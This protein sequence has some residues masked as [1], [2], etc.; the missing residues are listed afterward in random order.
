MTKLIKTNLLISIIVTIISFAYA[1]PN[2]WNMENNLYL[3]SRG[4]N[5]GLDLRGGSH[6]LLKVDI[7]KYIEDQLE[8]LSDNLRKHFREKKMGYKS[9]KVD[10]NS[11]VVTL[12]NPEDAKPAIKIASSVDSSLV[13]E[14]LNDTI[15]A[16]Y[17]E[18]R[19]AT[20]RENVIDQSI[21]IVRMRVDSAG[22]KEPV[23]QKQGDEYIILQVPGEGN[24]EHLKKL[25]G[26]TA[27]LTLH[28]IE[29]GVRGSQNSESIISQDEYGNNIYLQKKPIITG[30]M[31]INAAATFDETS[32]PAINFS[33]NTIGAKLFGEATKNNKGKR[34]AIVLDNKILSSPRVSEPILRGEGV[35]KGSF[36]ISSAEDLAL[37]LRAGAL[38]AP[39]EVIEE[40]VIGASL[41]S[42]SIESGKKAGMIGLAGVMVFMVLSYGIL[43]I[44]A[45]IALSF[46]LLYIIAILS[47]IQA[48]LTLPGIAGIILTIGMAVDANVLIYERIREEA[49]RKNVSILY[50][51]N[52]GFNAAFGTIADSNIT[53]L[54]SACL[55]YIFGT[56]AIKGFAVSLSIGIL[57]SMFTALVLTRLFTEIWLKFYKPTKLGI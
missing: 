44:F 2:F 52:Q 42:D 7:D 14:S 11:L 21:E 39:L 19:L 48:T 5:L 40:K 23:I 43:G 56:G 18:Y 35:I 4:V 53:T 10:G 26:Q 51:V 45:N 27:K 32:N 25:L 46:S 37:L 20:F 8:I 12:R 29:E 38:P 50:A 30:G 55:L 28:I 3:P 57:S 22:T 41:G 24:P 16:K 36:S 31:L 54:I 47:A 6:L 33:L 34:I 49:R 17:N 1:A 9:M 15:T 13:V